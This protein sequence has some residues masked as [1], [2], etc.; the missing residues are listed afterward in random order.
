MKTPR[1]IE[2]QLRPFVHDER[3]PVKITEGELIGFLNRLAQEASDGELDH[4]YAD[5]ALLAHIGS[6][7]VAQAFFKVKRY[8]S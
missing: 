6:H 5:L 7:E 2:D 3:L 8:Y 4:A 1:E